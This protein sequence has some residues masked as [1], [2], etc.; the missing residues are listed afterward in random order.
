M[1]KW[2]GQI[3]A[4]LLVVG[5]LI[6]TIHPSDSQEDESPPEIEPS[7]NLA[8]QEVRLYTTGID[9]SALYDIF[10]LR[11]ETQAALFLNPN[12]QPVL[13]SAQEQLAALDWV[14]LETTLNQALAQN[15]NDPFANFTL[16]ILYL[17]PTYLEPLV[18]TPNEYQA[19]AAAILSILNVAGYQARD[20]GLRLIEHQHWALAERLFSQQLEVDTDDAFAYAYR[21]FARD[22]RGENGLNDLENAIALEPALPLGFYFLGLHYRQRDNHDKSLS[23][24]ID[25]YLL[26]EQNPAL[27]AEVAAAYQ[28]TNQFPLADEWY[29]LAESLAPNDVRFMGLR[30]AFYADSEYTKGFEYVGQVAE[31]YPNDPRIQSS[32]GR[33]LFHQDELSTGASVFEHALTLTPN[34]LR[35]RLYY[36]ELLERQGLDL[37]AL[38]HYRFVAQTD[39]PFRAAA[40][41]GIRRVG[42]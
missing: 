10:R 24:L 31:K 29:T 32:W 35:T 33:V 40:E 38:E 37:A 7:L 9:Q 3:L 6:W 8:L 28:L 14:G 16:G 2:L 42:Q 1:V 39:N 36:A 41:R 4:R 12:P 27:A 23:Y 5:V 19:E 15:P 21:G 26:D 17:E 18:A 34:D 13:T 30:A 11:G 25:A 20:V 22:Q